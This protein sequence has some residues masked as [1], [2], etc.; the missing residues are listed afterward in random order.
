[1]FPTCF[2]HVF[3][4]P[5]DLCSKM[6]VNSAKKHDKRHDEVDCAPA[7]LE[8]HL[9]GILI[10]RQTSRTAMTF[11]GYLALFNLIIWLFAFVLSMRAWRPLGA[12]RLGWS[13]SFVSY[14]IFSLRKVVRGCSLKKTI[15]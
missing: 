9:R 6:C 8:A 13:P 15:F 10:R 7:G 12:S 3:G 14:F 11:F 4:R 2:L 5:S 1:M